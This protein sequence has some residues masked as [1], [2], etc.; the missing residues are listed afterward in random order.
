MADRGS[1]KQVTMETL[2][3]AKDCTAYT[4]IVLNSL[5]IFVE[6]YPTASFIFRERVIMMREWNS[7]KTII[8]SF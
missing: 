8:Y 5:L 1:G 2:L 4:S 3:A 6:M 7:L